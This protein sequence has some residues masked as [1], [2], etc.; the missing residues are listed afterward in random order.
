MSTSERLAEL[1][2][3]APD[4]PA[5]IEVAAGGSSREITY[6]RLADDVSGIAD[7]LRSW[8]REMDGDAVVCHPATVSL[9]TTKIILAALCAGVTVLPYAPQLD[10]EVLSSVLG[11]AGLSTRTRYVQVPGSSEIGQESAIAVHLTRWERTAERRRPRYLLTTSGSTGIPKVVPFWN[12]GE[13]DPRVI[14]DIV[15]RSCGWQTGQRQLVTLP[16]YHIG[17]VAAL[18]QG[19]LDRNQI[20]LAKLME[21]EDLLDTIADHR[22]DWLMVT[23]NYM[24]T[25]LPA[26]T[27]D[28]GRLTSLNGILHTALPCP[29]PLKQAWIDLLGGERVF[30]MY[31]GT[32][33]VGVTVING[34]EWMAKPGSVGRGLLTH[35]RI[36]DAQ[37]QERGADGIGRIYLRRLGV[38]DRAR[39][40]TPWLQ[41]TTDGFVSLGD[42]GW[43]D[44]DGYLYV[45]D[46]AANQAATASGV[47]W[48]GRLSLILRTHPDVLDAE[49]VALTGA[50]GVEIGA[51]LVLHDSVADLDPS[52]IRDFCASRINDHEFPQICLRVAEIPRSE[53]GKPDAVAITRIFDREVLRDTRA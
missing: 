46:R 53:I 4:F 51:L 30:E 38:A 7:L 29:A 27:R 17:T 31:G 47:T 15:F 16:I 39:S 48:L 18:V 9:E 49:C 19:V 6:R 28:P 44:Q 23:P 22:I 11:N 43:V 40:A 50:E 3:E 45:F 12:L 34:S 10:T 14:P 25:L 1:A 33:G 13:Y 36:G 2:V 35:L 41:H 37:G 21:P 24:K 52:A 42:M 32:E 26:A 20:V 5:I 8:N